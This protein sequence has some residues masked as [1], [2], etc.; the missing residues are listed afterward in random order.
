LKNLIKKYNGHV[1]NVLLTIIQNLIYVKCV[2]QNKAI[3]HYKNKRKK[4]MH[5]T[6][7]IVHFKMKVLSQN[8]KCVEILR[9]H[10]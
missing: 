2:R 7:K 6:A 10:D 9:K 5:G 1:N 3:M 8:V 4:T